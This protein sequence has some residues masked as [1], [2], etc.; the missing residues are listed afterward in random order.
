[1]RDEPLVMTAAPG[2]SPGVTVLTLKGPLTLQ[3]MFGFQQQIQEY[4]PQVLILDLT[5][6]QYMD[7]AGLGA[8]MNCFV[9]AQ[10]AGRTLLLAGANERISALLE[11][12]KVH[13]VLKN[14]PTASEAE[15]SLQH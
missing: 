9:S 15:T 8:I 2:H 7:S 13:T 12:T 5:E 14:Y 6:S 4:K 3:N 10:K 11:S 1:M